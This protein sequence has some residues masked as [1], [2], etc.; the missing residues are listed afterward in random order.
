M[1]SPPAA[2]ARKHREREEEEGGP[3]YARKTHGVKPLAVVV[4]ADHALV[5]LG[6]VPAGF[7]DF[8]LAVSAVPRELLP[9]RL[10]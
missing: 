9:V 4:E 7:L 6:A 10:R 2:V 1:V 3:G 5:A 8:G